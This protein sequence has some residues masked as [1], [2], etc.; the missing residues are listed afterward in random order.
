MELTAADLTICRNYLSRRPGPEEGVEILLDDI[1]CSFFNTNRDDKK[2]Q[3]AK[4]LDFAH[5]LKPIPTEVERQEA[6]KKFVRSITG[7]KPKRRVKV[8]KET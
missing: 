2:T 6:K 4:K 5:W 1:N 8:A 7:G 3:P